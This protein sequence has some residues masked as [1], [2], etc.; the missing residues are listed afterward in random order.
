MPETVVRVLTEPEYP[1]WDQLVD[2]SQQG[3]IFHTSGWITTVS[4]NLAIDHLIIGV[5]KKSDLIGGCFFYLKKKFHLFTIASTQVP[6]VPY[7]GFVISPSERTKVQR[8]ESREHEIISLILEKIKTLNFAHT[9]ITNGPGFTDIR[10]FIWRGWREGVA[11]TYV[12][13]LEGD[14]LS[15]VSYAARKKIQKAQKTGITAKKE[16]DPGVYWDLTEKTYEKQRS[17]A[18]F[19]KEY[20]VSL[21]TMLI[22]NNLGEMWIARTPE[23]EPASAV[24]TLYDTKMA[25][26]WVGANDPEFKNTGVGPFLFFEIFMDLQNR[27]FH[28]VNVMGGNNPHLAQFY[29][30]FNP[31]LVPYYSVE[32][33]PDITQFLYPFRKVKMT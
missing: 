19:K 29:S 15:A 32:R 21:M 23:G 13:S 14:I 16:Y 3:T 27:G 25:H 24:F 9:M 31:R 28:Q 2:R 30:N 26:T 5:F 10:P 33:L 4:K 18:P 8:T 22:R 1:Q 11:Y 17:E 6:L 7:G 20:L 12:L